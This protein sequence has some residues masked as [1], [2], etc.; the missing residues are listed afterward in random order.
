MAG[1]QQRDHR[2][3]QMRVKLTWVALLTSF[4]ARWAALAQELDLAIATYFLMHWQA[5]TVRVSAWKS[6][7]QNTE[8]EITKQA[9]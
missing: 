8:R 3:R 1:H 6:T 5:L 4:L 9:A 7:M 2:L